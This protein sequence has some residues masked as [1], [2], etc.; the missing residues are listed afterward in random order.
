LAQRLE[1]TGTDDELGR[2]ASVLNDM[3]GR[4][5]RSFTM[6]GQF[7]A[8]AAHELRTPLTILKGEIEVSLAGTPSIAEYQRVLS[9]CLEEVDRLTALVDDLLFLARA[10]AGRVRPDER[11]DL[12]AVVADVHPALEALADRADV[13]LN[14]TTQPVAVRGSA[15]MLFR[16]LFNLGDNAIKYCNPGGRVDLELTRQGETAVTTVRDNGQ[17]NPVSELPRVYDRFYR[18][19]P[20][21]SRGGT[22][23]GLAL[24][25]AI[26]EIHGGTITAESDEGKGSTFRIRLPVIA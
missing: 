5:E 16:A 2:L 24:T 1:G 17:G 10:D 25:K 21:R 23:L 22:G 9:S 12:A 26:V 20:A 4:L 6:V 18:G 14:V 7:S 13:Q 3:L 11:V 15:A 8:D 19:D